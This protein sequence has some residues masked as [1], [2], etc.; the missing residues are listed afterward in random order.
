MPDTLTLTVAM[1]AKAGQEDRL[2]E[3][4]T[5]MIE[6]TEAEAG[7]LSYRPLVDPNTHGAMLIVEEWVDR[8]ALDVH[9]TTPHFNRIAAVLDE[10]LA[11]SYDLRFLRPAADGGSPG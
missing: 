10:V 3:E 11:E 4:L 2:R 5:G 7:C 6:P 8:T 9:F 1:Q